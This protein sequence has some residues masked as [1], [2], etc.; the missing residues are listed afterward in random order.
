MHRLLSLLSL[1]SLLLVVPA[2]ANETAAW[3][4]LARGEAVL[5]LRHALAPG[6][7][8]PDAFTLGD[9]STQRNLNETGRAQA[10]AWGPYLASHGIHQARVFTSQWCRC[11]DTAREMGVGEVTD[12]PSLNSFF[13]GRGDGEQQTR[14]TITRVNGLPAGAPVVLVTH[15]VNIS[16]LSGAYTSSNEGLILALPLSRPAEVLARVAPN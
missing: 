16:A 9:C 4:A 13:Q 5:V 10:R 7:G 1:L 11:R 15:Q 12:M 6:F 8:D 14:D 2:S 3:Q